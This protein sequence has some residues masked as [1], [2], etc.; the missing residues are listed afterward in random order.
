MQRQVNLANKIKELEEEANRRMMLAKGQ[1]TS[2]SEEKGDEQEEKR[3]AASVSEELNGNDNEEL[4]SKPFRL[5]ARQLTVQ[6]L[7]LPTS[8][9]Q[10]TNHQLVRAAS[11]RK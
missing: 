2:I 3:E 6:D 4:E 8:S 5:S 1:P 11:G 9:D 10:S 7:N